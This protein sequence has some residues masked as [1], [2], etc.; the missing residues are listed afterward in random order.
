MTGGIEWLVDGFGCDP[1]RLREVGAL[2]AVSEALIAE[3][4]LQVLGE[5]LLHRFAGPGGVTGLYLLSESHLA[6]HTYPECELA[7][8]NLYCCRER[9]APDWSALLA[10]RLGAQRV[11]VRSVARGFGG[12]A[13]PSSRRPLGV[14]VLDE[15]GWTVAAGTAK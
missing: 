6:W 9:P 8:F 13:V 5:P 7:T 11:E 2:A 1:E 10:A 12:E 4:G 3:L 15:R 14:S